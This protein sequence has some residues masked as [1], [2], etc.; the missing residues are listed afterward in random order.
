MVVALV[1][2]DHS[3]LCGVGISFIRVPSGEIKI[4]GVMPG[5]PAYL[6]EAVQVGDVLVRVDGQNVIG[7]SQEDIINMVLGPP[8]S[9]VSLT[10][11]SQYG[12]PHVMTAPFQV[13]PFD[14]RR[15]KKSKNKKSDSDTDNNFISPQNR[16][17]GG[18]TLPKG[19]EHLE[20]LRSA[21]PYT[22]PSL[23]VRTVHLQRQLPTA[24]LSRSGTNE[25]YEEAHSRDLQD[26][27]GAARMEQNHSI[28]Q[29]P[30]QQHLPSQ[31][32]SAMH[33]TSQPPERPCH[34]TS[35]PNP[36]HFPIASSMP[37]QAPP[38]NPAAPQRMPAGL[39][40]GYTMMPEDSLPPGIHTNVSCCSVHAQ[41]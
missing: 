28:I 40:A 8:E 24:L 26:H 4:T 5:S 13:L 7:R 16:L 1:Q 38:P 18:G 6:C 34:Y 12:Y 3:Q 2:T 33:Q 19:F 27:Q 41:T 29:H 35:A 10:I 37:T 25:A 30:S 39:P 31:Q 22:T 15:N 14:N 32:Y 23:S 17:Y 20:S 11:Q 9:S 36:M 21:Q